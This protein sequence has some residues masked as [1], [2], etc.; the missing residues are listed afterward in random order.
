M[1][2]AYQMSF[3][4]VFFHWAHVCILS[5]MSANT[6]LYHFDL[7]MW[8]VYA[9]HNI[10]ERIY[11]ARMR[12]SLRGCSLVKS[13]LSLSLP[14]A[15]LCNSQTHSHRPFPTRHSKSKSMPMSQWAVERAK[16]TQ[17]IEGAPHPGG[18]LK[19]LV[20]HIYLISQCC[21]SM[22]RR[23]GIICM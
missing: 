16:P 10:C 9:T 6:N 5:T 13:C 23:W 1:F 18:A 21:L 4:E 17:F 12:R 14:L 15:A 22:L 19:L 20:L 8:S 7:W 11:L 2:Q 3:S